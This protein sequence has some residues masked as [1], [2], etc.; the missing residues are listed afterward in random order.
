MSISAM[1]KKAVG[2]IGEHLVMGELLKR[3]IEAYLAN[4]KTQSGWDIVVVVTG[5]KVKR[6]Q[7]KTTFLQN[8]NTN[9]SFKI[10]TGYDFLVLVVIDEQE[11]FYVLSKDDV[12][13]I[14]GSSLQFGISKSSKGIYTVKDEISPHLSKWEKI[15]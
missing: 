10:T 5:D 9:N 2:A 11:E 12:T 7:V 14:Q 3:N 8:K 4:S 6:I 13:N 1:T 15:A